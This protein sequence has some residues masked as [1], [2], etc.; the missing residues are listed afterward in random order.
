MVGVVFLVNLMGSTPP[1]GQIYPAR[2]GTPTVYLP[3][4]VCGHDMADGPG[5]SWGT[6]TSRAP[7][8]RVEVPVH[9]H[10]S[11]INNS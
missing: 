11:A 9:E 1:L 6:I 5:V 7:S 2:P 10:F 3:L 4:R 8:P